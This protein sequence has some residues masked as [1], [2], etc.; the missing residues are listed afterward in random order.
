VEPGKLY[1]VRHT[2]SRAIAFGNSV[3]F[4]VGDAQGR[5]SVL[6]YEYLGVH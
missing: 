4:P 6:N 2:L 1:F 3:F 5:N